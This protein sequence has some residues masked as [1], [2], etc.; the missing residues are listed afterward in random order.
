MKVGR[1]MGW[2]LTCHLVDDINWLWIVTSDDSELG[3]DDDDDNDGDDAYDDGN[4]DK[5]KLS[6]SPKKE[7]EEDRALG[8]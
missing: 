1:N 5:S 7:S 8:N 3:D 2:V 4:A 6:P